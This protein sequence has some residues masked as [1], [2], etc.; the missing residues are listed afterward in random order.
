MLRSSL[1]R[2]LH[3]RPKLWA[4]LSVNGVKTSSGESLPMTAPS[5][6]GALSF[7]ENR[8]LRKAHLAPSVKAHYDNTEAGP[9]HVAYGEGQYLYDTAGRRYLDCVNNVCHVGHCHPRVVQAATL[10]LGT[11]NTNSRYLHDNIVRL[12]QELTSTL[13]DPLS[14]V[15]FTN[16]GSEANDL[17]LRLARVHTGRSDVYCVDG[18]YHGHTAAT[19]AIS[20]YSKYAAIE[21]PAGVVKLSQPDAYRLGL[22]PEEVT[23][24][25]LKEY[26]TWLAKKGTEARPPAAFI[27]ESVMCCGGQIVL[28]PGYLRGIYKRTRDAGGITIADEV[29]TGFGRIG[30]HF[31]AFQ[32][33]GEDVVPDIMT[34]GKPFGNGFPL[35]AVVTTSTVAASAQNIEYF[36]TFGGNPV[37]CAVGLEV[38]NVIRR[39]KL[40][41]NAL[42]VG[43]YV[44]KQL[45][46]L[47]AKHDKIGDVRGIGLLFGVELVSNRSTKA[48]D[49]DAATFVM[50]R[51]KSM[52]VLVST[53]GPHRNV[54]KMK[55]PIC[56]TREN[57]DEVTRVLDKV[58]GELVPN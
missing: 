9:L 12:A 17:A 1:W 31:W 15:F 43:N 33:Q 7:E 5:K 13:P 6:R 24:K 56:F 22:T 16:S 41:Q 29:Q 47:G 34:V 20:P 26:D 42:E 35:S 54:V 51:M 55:P 14:V 8:R 4:R 49:A 58:L 52:G 19:L 36:N 32:T 44:I 48:P 45:A 38:L 23:A 40:Q 37:A 3:G 25:S 27:I 53:D 21:T 28:P 50:Q 39:E 46:A 30:S 11:L 18:A 10:Q 57:A 2:S